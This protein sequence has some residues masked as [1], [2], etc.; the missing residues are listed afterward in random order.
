[1]ARAT[2]AVEEI[3]RRLQARER[4]EFGTYSYVKPISAI[5]CVDGFSVS[6]QAKSG[7]YCSPRDDY[8][9]WVSF[10]LGFPSAPDELIAAYAEDPSDPTGTVYGYVPADVVEA[11][12]QRHGGISDT[13]PQEA[14]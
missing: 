5:Q 4:H 13:Q 7:S 1:M 6:V 11:L 2:T 8:G 9:P 14:V 12:I 3:T 10:E